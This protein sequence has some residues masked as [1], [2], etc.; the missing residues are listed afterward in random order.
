MLRINTPS[1]AQTLAS[2]MSTEQRAILSTLSHSMQSLMHPDPKVAK[3]EKSRAIWGRSI[4]TVQRDVQMPIKL[5]KVIAT[6]V[7][8]LEW[9][10]GV[11]KRHRKMNEN[12]LEKLGWRKPVYGEFGIMN[13]P[14]MMTTKEGYTLF[15]YHNSV[16]ISSPEG[17][18][19]TVEINHYTGDLEYYRRERNYTNKSL[20]PFGRAELTE[21]IRIVRTDYGLISYNFPIFV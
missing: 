7:G 3:S 6:A 11:E 16:T 14:R 4:Q 17:W 8:A 10:K 18:M 13:R 15:L 2:K 19:L 21:A 20:T 9:G 5:R 1:V 12:H